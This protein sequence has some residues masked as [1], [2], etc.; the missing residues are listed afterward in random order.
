MF[1]SRTTSG[2][3]SIPPSGANEPWMLSS[4]CSSARARCSPCV[5][6]FE[7]LHWIDGETQAVLDG[8]VES[9]PTARVLL[10]V[11]YRPEYRH[12]WGGKTY[13]RQLRVDTLPAASAADLLQA[14][15]GRGPEP[16]PARAAADRA[17]GRQ[18]AL[19]RG[20]RADAGRD[21]GPRRARGRLPAHAGAGEPADPGDGAG[22]HRGARSIGCAPE[23]KRLLQAAAVIGKDVPFVA[24]R[25]DRR[26]A[27][28][29]RYVDGLARLQ[30]AE[31]LYEA[32]LFPEVEYTFKHALTHE[33]AYGGLLQERRA[34]FTRESSSAIE[35]LHPDRLGGASRAARSSCLPR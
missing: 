24:A 14:L 3:G 15:L 32:R 19:P 9:L 26:P 11:N 20:E 13:Y 30:A 17:N 6:V 10:L 21:G 23:D 1:P 7:D 35:S 12:G 4:A 28:G 31:F 16:G 27:R 29:R 33:V 8:L 25:S 18:P 2:R 34:T 5:V 22:D